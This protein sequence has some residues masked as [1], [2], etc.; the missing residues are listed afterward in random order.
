MHNFPKLL[1][2]RFCSQ[3]IAKSRLRCDQMSVDSPRKYNNPPDFDQ[4]YFEAF[5]FCQSNSSRAIFS[6]FVEYASFVHL[7]ERSTC[8]RTCP[9]QI[10]V[11]VEVPLMI[12]CSLVENEQK[13]HPFGRSDEPEQHFPR[14]CLYLLNGTFRNPTWRADRLILFIVNSI[15]VASGNKCPLDESL[16][17]SNLQI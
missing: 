15:N 9:F 2:D 10:S 16:F 4:A 5:A 14:K 6:F 1:Q 7:V 8:R 17:V 3:H 13:E 12:N 11:P